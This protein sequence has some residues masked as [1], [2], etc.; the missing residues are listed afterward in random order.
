MTV[1]QKKAIFMSICPLPTLA[2]P[3]R[4]TVTSWG[5]EN[6]SDRERWR[7]QITVTVE[8]GFPEC[9]REVVGQGPEL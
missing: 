4:N 9:P 1:Q 7:D 2:C 5:E 8:D 3:V 6:H